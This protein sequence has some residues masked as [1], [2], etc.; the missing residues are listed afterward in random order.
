MDEAARDATALQRQLAASEDE[1][2]LTR[3]D[4][5]ENEVIE[6][7]AEERAAFVAAVQPVLLRHR[8]QF[9]PK[10]FAY[11]SSPEL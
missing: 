11:L 1:D 6:L 10:L 4:P 7:T 8:Q 9:D 5:R 3:L 2:V